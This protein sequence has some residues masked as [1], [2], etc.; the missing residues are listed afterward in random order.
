[1]AVPCVPIACGSG[2]WGTAQV[3]RQER[4][5]LVQ[6]MSS[7]QIFEPAIF[8]YG[9]RYVTAGVSGGGGCLGRSAATASRRRNNAQEFLVAGA[10]ARRPG[11]AWPGAPERWHGGRPL[12][13]PAPSPSPPTSALALKLFPSGGLAQRLQTLRPLMQTSP[14]P[15]PQR[16][17][18]P[19]KPSPGEKRGHCARC[20]GETGCWLYRLGESGAGDAANFRRCSPAVVAPRSSAT[21]RHC[22]R[23]PTSSS[24]CA[25]PARR[26]GADARGHHPHRPIWP[27]QNPDISM[28]QL[29]AKGHG[30]GISTSPHPEPS[31]EDG[32]AHFHR[33]G[34]GYRCRDRGSQRFG[35]ALTAR[36]RPQAKCR[37]PR[38]SLWALA[39][40]VALAAI[41]TAANLAPS[42]AQ[43]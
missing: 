30:A 42:C 26:S 35:V 15:Q 32:R 16:M 17:A 14:V 22:G 13:H 39:W 12:G 21:L 8:A 11:P 3:A 43:Q 7:R 4:T 37:P 29:A 18:C 2:F 38:C 10:P 5:D 9:Y 19:G 34:Q 31:P 27:A 20:G 1:M 24:R 6:W 25:C 41:G 23:H 28:Q 36:S 33:R 40:R